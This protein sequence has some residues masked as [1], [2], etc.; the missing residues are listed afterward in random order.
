ME[1]SVGGVQPTTDEAFEKF[2]SDH[3]FRRKI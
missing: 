3:K 2:F 1:L